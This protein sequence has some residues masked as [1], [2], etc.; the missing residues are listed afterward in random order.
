MKLSFSASL[1]ALAFAVPAVAGPI[2]SGTTNTG[3]NSSA[4][5]YLVPV[6]SGWRSTS[7][8]TVGDSVDG[9]RMVGIP[10]GLGAYD[11]GDGTVTVLMNHELGST[12]GVVRAHGQK[13]SFVSQWTINKETLQVTKGRDLINSLFL[14][15]SLSEAI[16]RL[17]SADLP[18]VSAFY[19][20]ASGKGYSGRIFMT[21]EEAGANGRQFGVDVASGI[22]YELSKLGKFSHENAVARP[23]GGDRTVVFGTDDSTPGQVYLYVGQKTD[24][25][26]SVERAGLTNG[27][28]FGIKINAGGNETRDGGLPGGP[29]FNET[30]SVSLV[31]IDTS[32]D[33]N[34]QNADANAAGVTNFLR[35]EDAHW[36]PTNPNRLYFVTTDDN[37]EEGGKSRLYAI[38]FTNLES[39][40]IGGSISMLLDGTEGPEMMDNI[41][42]DANGR[43]VIQEDPG[44]DSDLAKI[45]VYDPASDS[46]E[47]VFQHDPKRFLAGASGFLT[48]NEES[49]GVIDVTDLFRDAS[50][51]S[52]SGAIQIFLSTVQAH[53]RLTDSEL[54]E[55]G[56]LL[57]LSRVPEP[58]ALSLFGLGMAG[59]V[60]A[61]R[62][63]R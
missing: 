1:L 40:E 24:S 29:G 30:G 31:E 17:C 50:W 25:G 14:D 55:G 2:G 47:M 39:G 38:D 46:V 7:L 11:N 43:V 6:K 8:L 9:Y 37:L 26:S 33:G 44:G 35:P 58:A 23:G 13:G 45:W 3:P 57:L 22:A 15:G 18:E 16:N 41:T 10:D 34:T 12:A 32:G 56:Q 5:P 19:N 59:L 60:I 61:R 51:F 28:L 20:A 53:Y 52:A 42:V 63:R 36:D 62:R 21:G 48:E 49:S 4:S 54:V 27:K